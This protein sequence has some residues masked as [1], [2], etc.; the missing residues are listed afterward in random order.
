MPNGWEKNY[1]FY[2][3]WIIKYSYFQLNLISIFNWLLLKV[4][5]SNEVFFENNQSKILKTNALADD[6]M[7]W[8]ENFLSN[9]FKENELN[10]IYECTVNLIG[11]VNELA[12]SYL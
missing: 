11:M 7:V 9:I 4:Y 12:C 2:K 3:S 1:L 5:K 10:Y 6:G 8:K